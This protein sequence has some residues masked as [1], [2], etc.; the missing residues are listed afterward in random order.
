MFL[1]VKLRFVVT[2]AIDDIPGFAGIGADDLLPQ[3]CGDIAEMEVEGEPAFR[4]SRV[5]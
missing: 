2:E 4:R 1:N 5:C 3:G